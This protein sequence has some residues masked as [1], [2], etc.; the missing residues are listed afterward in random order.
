MTPGLP[1]L[2]RISIDIEDLKNYR[3]RR[4]CP[5][6]FYDKRG[7]TLINCVNKCLIKS[8]Q[9]FVIQIVNYSMPIF[10]HSFVGER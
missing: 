5:S 2:V 8:R 4:V 3:A 7:R 10:I 6:C 1:I 9:A